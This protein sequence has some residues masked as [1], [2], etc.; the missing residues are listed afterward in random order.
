MRQL[1]SKTYED[2]MFK[3]D[4]NSDPDIKYIPN[5]SNKDSYNVIIV[6]LDVDFNVEKKVSM[7]MSSIKALLTDA[8]YVKYTQ[9]EK[10]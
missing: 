2:E 4:V 6:N 9:V 1:I 8:V 5:L 3:L 10:C 7:T